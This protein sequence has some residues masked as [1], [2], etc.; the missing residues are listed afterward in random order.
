MEVQPS[1]MFTS[2]STE[3]LEELIVQTILL[4]VIK[5]QTL[6]LRASLFDGLIIDVPVR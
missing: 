6:L 2:Q 3:I 1:P 4:E 5:N